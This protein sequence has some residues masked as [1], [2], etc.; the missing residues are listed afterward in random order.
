ML[1]KACVDALVRLPS[2]ENIEQ[3]ARLG[4]FHHGNFLPGVSEHYFKSI[5]SVLSQWEN[6]MRTRTQKS[7][8]IYFEKGLRAEQFASGHVDIIKKYKVADD[9]DIEEPGRYSMRISTSK[10]EPVYNKGLERE[11]RR[12]L[13]PKQLPKLFRE[14]TLLK[15]KPGST[16]LYHNKEHH[17]DKFFTG[18]TWRSA[19][20]TSVMG[21]DRNLVHFDQAK[22][23]YL[24]NTWVEVLCL[25]GMVGKKA[26]YIGQYTV[27]VRLGNLEPLTRYG[28][29]NPVPPYIP[30]AWRLKERTS[31]TLWPGMTIDLTKTTYTKSS[32]QHCFDGRGKVSWEVEADW[33][34]KIN[35]ADDFV[36]A[37]NAIL[38]ST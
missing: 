8:A 15:I 18:L 34:T 32:I 21:L 33:D 10:E 3:E 29:V 36:E 9:I 14:G 25:P 27:R 38:H 22:E 7:I 19:S 1:S 4:D 13:K 20:P 37:V 24:P 17:A 35:T 30:T 5:Q 31:Y 28:Y 26:L 23:E 12:F 2:R 16:V 6:K 11:I